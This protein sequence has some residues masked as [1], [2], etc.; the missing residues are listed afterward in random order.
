MIPDDSYKNNKA[1]LKYEEFVRKYA[2]GFDRLIRKV[3]RQHETG[4][5]SLKQKEQTH[6][7]LLE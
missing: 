2:D 7:Q 5:M 3:R 6:R 1:R 4:Q